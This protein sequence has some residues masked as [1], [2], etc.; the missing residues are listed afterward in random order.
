MSKES[1]V[2]IRLD[3]ERGFQ[4]CKIALKKAIHFLECEKN[5]KTDSS[6]RCAI[7]N[8]RFTQEHFEQ[9]SFHVSDSFESIRRNIKLLYAHKGGLF[10][11]ADEA[12]KEYKDYYECTADNL[13]RFRLKCLNE[14]HE[15]IDEFHCN[16]IGKFTNTKQFHDFCLKNYNNLALNI[17]KQIDDFLHAFNKIRKRLKLIRLLIDA[18]DK[19][20]LKVDKINKKKLET[21]K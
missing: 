12:D 18:C 4:N 11:F 13:F 9:F 6:I 10:S 5:F 14:I 20:M 15:I 16:R 8:L 2:H 17:R 19:K 7:F 1:D 21:S 3:E